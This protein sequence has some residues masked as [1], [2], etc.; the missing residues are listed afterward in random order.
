MNEDQK[1]ANTAMVKALEMCETE[2]I[3]LAPRL[4]AR[5][6]E[7]AETCAEECKKA[8]ALNAAALAKEGEGVG[9]PS[10]PAASAE[11]LD[12]LTAE[13]VCAKMYPA[14][15]SGYR[16]NEKEQP[17]ANAQRHLD[18]IRTLCSPATRSGR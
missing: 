12:T 11:P 5:Y 3:T 16:E 1:S 15:W 8:L 9:A 7:N 10:S 6:R 14:T 17:L 13:Q 18:A 2:F 4:T